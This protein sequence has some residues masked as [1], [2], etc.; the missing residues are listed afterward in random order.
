M[1]YSQCC[2]NLLILDWSRKNS[3]TLNANSGEYTGAT[4]VLKVSLNCTCS[5][6]SKYVRH[7]LVDPTIPEL[8]AFLW[9]S[10]D[11][12]NLS[13]DGATCNSLKIV[14]KPRII[15]Y[16]LK[17]GLNKLNILLIPMDCHIF[18]HLVYKETVR[19][20]ENWTFTQI[21]LH[22]WIYEVKKL[23]GDIMD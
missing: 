3:R 16:C 6:D 5:Q 22:F 18:H 12:S 19:N 10:P 14:F 20:M 21:L 15:R 9:W 8:W 7:L 13:L 17:K 1:S 4:T 11:L 23:N 2:L